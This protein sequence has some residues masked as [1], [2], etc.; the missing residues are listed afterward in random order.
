MSQCRPAPFDF[1]HCEREI[2]SGIFQLSI[3]A[4]FASSLTMLEART[5]ALRQVYSP[6]RYVPGLASI[7]SLTASNQDAVSFGSSTETGRKR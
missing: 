3:P 2:E 5:I 7:H 1:A 6:S 4:G